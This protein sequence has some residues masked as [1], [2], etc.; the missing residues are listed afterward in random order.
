MMAAIDITLN[1][2]NRIT[3]ILQNCCLS[4]VTVKAFIQAQMSWGRYELDE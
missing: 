4:F 1:H 2:L 3:I